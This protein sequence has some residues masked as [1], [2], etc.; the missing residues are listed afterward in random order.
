VQKA[1]PGKGTVGMQAVQKA[2]LGKGTVGKPRCGKYCR[3]K[4]KAEYIKK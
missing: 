2:L 3:H 4:S 1:L